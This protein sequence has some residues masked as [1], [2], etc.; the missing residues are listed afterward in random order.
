MK[1]VRRNKKIIGVLATKEEYEN[2]VN[3][4]VEKIIKG[5]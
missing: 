1:V 3:E 4:I 5:G 2:L